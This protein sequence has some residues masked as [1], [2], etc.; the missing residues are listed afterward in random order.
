MPGAR[1]PCTTGGIQNA[2]LTPIEGTLLTARDYYKGGW[3]NA[4]EGYTASCYPLP[5][6]CGKNF[7]VLLTDGLPSTDKNGVAIASTRHRRS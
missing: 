5:I 7:V 6:S 4:G 2:G 3:S 1:L